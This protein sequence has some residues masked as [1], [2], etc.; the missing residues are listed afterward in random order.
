MEEKAIVTRL[1][2]GDRLLTMDELVSELDL[3]STMPSESRRRRYLFYEKVWSPK[4]QFQVDFKVPQA[5]PLSKKA[6]EIT[7]TILS[8]WLGSRPI[9][10][11]RKRTA[12]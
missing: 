3:P 8:K 7:K 10:R 11:K 6:G 2:Y 5:V 12:A 1:P 4:A 9:P